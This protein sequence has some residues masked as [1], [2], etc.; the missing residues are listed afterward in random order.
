MPN[1]LFGESKD[2]LFIK[3]FGPTM[4]S[5]D[6]VNDADL[7]VWFINEIYHCNNFSYKL[8]NKSL[9]KLCR[10]DQSQNKNFNR[11]NRNNQQY[12]NKYSK[13]SNNQISNSNVNA[14]TNHEEEQE[15]NQHNLND[16]D[17]ILRTIKATIS[18]SYSTKKSNAATN[19]IHNLSIWSIDAD[20]TYCNQT[21]ISIEIKNKKQLEDLRNNQ[22]NVRIV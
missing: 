17:K 13:F 19:L 15:D 5:G 16:S 10:I 4:K 7:N 11:Q 14:I 21:W 18:N 12:R 6:N 22:Y 2:R 20:L 1:N 3:R 9:S 8:N